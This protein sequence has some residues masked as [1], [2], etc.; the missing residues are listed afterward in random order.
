MWSEQEEATFGAMFTGCSCS[1][2]TSNLSY[3]LYYPESAPGPLD[4]CVTSS[5]ASLPISI[6]RLSSLQGPIPSDPVVGSRGT[7][8]Y[9]RLLTS[10]GEHAPS[11]SD[12]CVSQVQLRDAYL[13]RAHTHT[14][15][16]RYGQVISKYLIKQG[17][18]SE[19]G[20]QDRSQYD[21]HTC[22]HFVPS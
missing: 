20:A 8:G 6:S 16:D 5:P 9:A 10:R 2:Q 1:T 11:L 13:Q 15:M 22:R 4:S 17:S 3:A 19:A 18:L 21:A 14:A 7:C 12:A